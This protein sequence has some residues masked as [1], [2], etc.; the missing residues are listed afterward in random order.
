MWWPDLILLRV[1]RH[2][3]T[4]EQWQASEPLVPASGVAERPRVDDRRVIN[5]CCIRSKQGSPGRSCRSATGRGRRST[6][7]LSAVVGHRCPDEAGRPGSGDRLRQR[8]DRL[9]R[10]NDPLAGPSGEVPSTRST[11]KVFEAQRQRQ[12]GYGPLPPSAL[13]GKAWTRTLRWP[14]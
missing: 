11:S 12:P 2:E 14:W 8:G 9:H 3:L 13:G 4:D 1:R 10:E 7:A 6:T 5:G